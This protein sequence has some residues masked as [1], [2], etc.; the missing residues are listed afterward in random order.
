MYFVAHGAGSPVRNLLALPLPA[1]PCEELEISSYKYKNVFHVGGRWGKGEG[2]GSIKRYV[3]TLHHANLHA[4]TLGNLAN[5]F[6]V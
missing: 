2:E 1:F 4:I 6:R 3:N 5:S